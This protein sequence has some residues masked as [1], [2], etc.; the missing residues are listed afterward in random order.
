MRTVFSWCVT[1]VATAET[2]LADHP[3]TEIVG[4]EGHWWEQSS[5]GRCLILL[6]VERDDQGR[7]VF[8]QIEDKLAS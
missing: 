4:R 8:K 3:A 1:F 6:A 2:G 7:D 5:G